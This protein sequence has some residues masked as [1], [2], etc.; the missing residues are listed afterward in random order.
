M[1]N[2]Y[3]ESI[4][5]VLRDARPPEDKFVVLNRLRAKIVNLQSVPLQKVLCDTDEH[6]RQP[7]EKPTLFMSCVCR[8][9]EAPE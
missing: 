7:D 5:A 6:D 1:E 9:D 8:N 4:Y 3:H 2:H